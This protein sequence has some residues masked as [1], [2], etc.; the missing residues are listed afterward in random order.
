M[1]YTL[2][3]YLI[4]TISNIF[5]G[6]SLVVKSCMNPVSISSIDSLVLYSS[7]RVSMSIASVRVGLIP[8]SV[9]THC[10]FFHSENPRIA[11][12][13]VR[14]MSRLS[15]W[16][17]SIVRECIVSSS[18]SRSDTTSNIMACPG[19]SSST[20][21]S[22][23]IASREPVSIPESMYMCLPSYGILAVSDMN[24]RTSMIGNSTL[25]SGIS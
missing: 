5:L 20:F 18:A 11:S 13:W 25:S 19:V 2:C 9:E 1:L 12:A 8:K 17:R 23:F 7:A 6:G 15:C 24:F 22:A 21:R 10:S 3:C 16:K 4:N 14:S